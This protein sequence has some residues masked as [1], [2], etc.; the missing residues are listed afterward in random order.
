MRRTPAR[1]DLSAPAYLR[2]QGMAIEAVRAA[3]KGGARTG[4]RTVRLA[5]DLKAAFDADDGKARL[6]VLFSPT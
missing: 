1:E 5:A 4:V 3:G 2:K 6:V